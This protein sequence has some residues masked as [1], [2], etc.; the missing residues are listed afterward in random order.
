MKLEG[1]SDPRNKQSPRA[2]S[3][4][5]REATVGGWTGTLCS[6]GVERKLG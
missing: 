3:T 1:K 2:D 5:V 4:E 6:L